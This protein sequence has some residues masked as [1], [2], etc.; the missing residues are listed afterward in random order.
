MER[1]RRARLEPRWLYLSVGALLFA[2]ITLSAIV[3]L[4]VGLYVHAVNDAMAGF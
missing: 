3:L 1:D 4:A 2:V